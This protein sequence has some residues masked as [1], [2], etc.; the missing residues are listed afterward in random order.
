MNYL[1]K[2]LVRADSRFKSRSGLGSVGPG[3]VERLIAGFLWYIGGI[4]IVEKI[5]IKQR[6]KTKQ[7]VKLKV[8]P[9]QEMKERVKSDFF[10]LPNRLAK[11]LGQ[12]F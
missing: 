1:K 7:E 2:S 3:S 10:Y 8:K 4:I 6:A 11:L 12:R 5:E 9:N